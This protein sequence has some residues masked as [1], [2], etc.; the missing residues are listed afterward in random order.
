MRHGR[1]RWIYP[2]SDEFIRQCWRSGSEFHH[3]IFPQ[4]SDDTLS[5]IS[6]KALMSCRA[7]ELGLSIPQF[8]ANPSNEAALSFA[9]Q[10]GYPVVVKGA[11]GMAGENVHIV[12]SDQ[13]LLTA[14]NEVAHDQPVVQ[15][16]IAGNTVLGGGLFLNG[17]A[18][19]LQLC[20][21][22]QL[23]P[24][25]TGP[26]IKVRSLKNAQLQRHVVT[27][28]AG[29][30]WT[31]L[32]SIDFIW[33]G[34]TFY[35]LELNPR[36]W[37]SITAAQSAGIDFFNPLTK[38]LQGITLIPNLSFQNHV[39]ACV[40]PGYLRYAADQKSVVILLRAITSMAFWR[41]IPKTSWPV[42]K[43]FLLRNVRSN[44]KQN[45]ANPAL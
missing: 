10:H 37:G 2:L 43:Y 41:G 45:T 1:T 38:L 4:L 9:R 20:E 16:F 26:S 31:G 15:Q 19:R 21:K 14:L 12:S 8:V 44:K 40:L 23:Y 25:S 27:L 6:N 22:T 5:L 34:D 39:E 36:P 7:Q 13:Q 3:L 32:A 18:L 11:T 29:L 17:Q 30:T 42:L 28:L 24:A 33:N 35:F